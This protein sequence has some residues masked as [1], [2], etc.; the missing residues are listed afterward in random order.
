[1]KLSVVQLESCPVLESLIKNVKFVYMLF[2]KKDPKSAPA[3]FRAKFGK[4]TIAGVYGRPKWVP[5]LWCAG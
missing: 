1:M 3:E 5:Q 2:N 4:E